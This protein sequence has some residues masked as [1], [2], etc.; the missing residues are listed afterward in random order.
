MIDFIKSFH[1]NG[2]LEILRNNKQ[3]NY[4]SQ[5]NEDTG[6]TELRTGVVE[7]LTFR[8]KNDHIEMY[9]SLHK[10]WHNGYNSDDFY[11]VELIACICHL[12]RS[13]SINPYDTQ[14]NK[15]EFGVNIDLPFEI[16]NILDNLISYKGFSFNDMN[17][18]P[19]IGKVVNFQRYSLK[20]YN[21]S[22][23]AGIKGRNT[24]RVEIHVKRMAHIGKIGIKYLSDLLDQNKMAE[25]GKMLVENF[26][27]IV[28]S[29]HSVDFDKID[30]SNR[31]LLSQGDNPK[32]WE[33]VK[34][35]DPKK[36]DYLRKKYRDIIR[37]NCR[38]DYQVMTSNLIAERWRQLLD[39]DNKPF[40]KLTHNGIDY[41]RIDF[42]KLT[43]SDRITFYEEIAK[44]TK[45][46]KET[47]SEINNLSNGLN[48]EITIMRKCKSCG[49][50]ISH[51]R[52]GAIFCEKKECRNK[53]SNTRRKLNKEINK[54]NQQP[55][56]FDPNLYLSI[57]DKLLNV[58]NTTIK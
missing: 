10:C 19:S 53:D 43:N 35:N 5:V 47:L 38:H 57:P 16:D 2:N 48:S 31:K 3:L 39:I 18:S 42:A 7:D 41:T 11:F 30:V 13:Y 33:R 4:R 8:D 15:L 6:E 34:K 24:L 36:N 44:L 29:N 32:Y 37:E 17:P 50:D 23:Q 20:L 1:I 45:S 49:M 54:Y 55:V 51:R 21:K 28:F 58:L 40:A 22:S 46:E 26:E 27:E 12:Y 14:I 25:L 56:L 9:G 52:K